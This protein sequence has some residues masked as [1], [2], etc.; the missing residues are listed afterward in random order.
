M[1]KV[2]KYEYNLKLEEIDKL[3]D[4]K[5]YEEAAR[6]ADTIDWKRVRNV[7]TL[8]LISEIYEA[9]GRMEDSKELL[10]RAYRRSPVGRT[11][12]Y[13]LVEVTT[14]LNQYDEAMEYYTEYVQAA[15]HDNNRYILKYQ[16][17]R[18]RG[19]SVEE[20]ISILEEYLGQEYT[21][22]WAYELAKLYQKAGQT[23]KCLATCD[24]LVLWFHSGKYVLKALELKK[25]YAPLTPKQQEIYEQQFMEPVQE[26]E[27][28]EEADDVITKVTSTDGEV[29]AES[30]MAETEKE[31]A[32]EVT[33]HKAELEQERTNGTAEDGKTAGKASGESAA[34]GNDSGIA[35]DDKSLQ[36]E[37]ARSMR[38]IV[39]GVIKHEEEEEESGPIVTKKLQAIPPVE[40]TGQNVRP[41][42]R[43][44]ID[45][46]L[47]SMGERGR[48]AARTVSED[49]EKTPYEPSG[50]ETHAAVESGGMAAH[51]AVEPGGMAADTAV[52]SGE[53]AADM[54]VEPGGM[55]ADTAVGSGGAAERAQAV[56]G[57]TG[58][59]MADREE[60][61]NAAQG[62]VSDVIWGNENDAAEK[63]PCHAESEAAERV[64]CHAE[65]EAAGEEKAFDEAAG[66][67]DHIQSESGMPRVRR[68]ISEEVED[69]LT[70]EQREALQY[71]NNPEKL[72]RNRSS[73]PTYQ[74]EQQIQMPEE[75]VSVSPDDLQ[76]TRRID[77]TREELEQEMLSGKTIRVPVEKIASLH[78]KYGLKELWQ[79]QGGLR[80]MQ[81]DVKEQAAPE[82]ADLAQEGSRQAE[83]ADRQQ[84]AEETP[85]S[86]VKERTG[87][88]I[89]ENAAS[90]SEKSGRKLDGA[91]DAVHPEEDQ[92]DSAYGYS[93]E[94]QSDPAYGYSGKNQGDPAYG[95]SVEDQNGPVYE[96]PAN[97]DGNGPEGMSGD[98]N[99][100]EDP[101]QQQPDMAEQS[102]RVSDQEGPFIPEHIRGLFSGFTEIEG[103][104]S[105]IA[106]AVIQAVANEGDRTSRSGNIL[107]F[108]PHGS[109]KT[110]LALNIAKAVAQ[111]KGTG[112][113]K[114]ARIYAADLNRKD[115]AA[116]IAKI[117]GGTLII[118]EAG[119]L[120]P[121]IIEQ[122]TTAMEF[123]TDG[124]LIILEDEEQYIHELLMSHPR[125]TM[126]FTSQ[127]YIPVYTADELLIFAQQSAKAQGYVIGQDGLEE[128]HGRISA[129]AEQGGSVSVTDVVELV[130][131]AVHKSNK[132]LR[133]MSMGKK[134]YDE[135]DYIILFA[136][137][138]K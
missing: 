63:V 17:Y 108:G 87:A 16:I 62:A 27:Q 45:D 4:Q 13:R 99:M 138:F 129:A 92:R 28:P 12:L 33:A 79:Q 25:K 47:L 15:P 114:L 91:Y 54:A 44:T 55:A 73:L 97:D 14:A 19:A 94:D 71:T 56:N 131:R 58:D 22:R 37:L 130:N 75:E 80:N 133:K 66:G 93:E 90:S 20:L 95:Y 120:E 101:Y 112:T 85:E 61:E 119:D 100:E 98:A 21:E 74:Q 30:I 117:A 103:L 132:L 82:A 127:I 49:A 125:F 104:E 72:L 1:T 26:E 43:L 46:V 18:G 86:A 96:E 83:S 113:L 6:M 89:S 102:R 105:Q 110:T 81:H 10:L 124:L 9:S 115:I 137:D 5:D 24:D 29:I 78:A 135:N 53:M 8:C 57:N 128:L 2:D 39:A 109:G 3:V 65:P 69:E 67:K 34:S 7:R 50:M 40:M 88:Y 36:M 60:A 123:R 118:E 31:I 111:D 77:Y 70:E 48:A 134:R 41:A 106:N 136:K 51:T 35:Y 121:G 42:G 59:S 76:K 23:Q 84:S 32:G 126:K 122:L 52:E 116:T 38:E 64:P 11:V 107:I 68:T